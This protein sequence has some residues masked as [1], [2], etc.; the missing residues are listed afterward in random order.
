MSTP[1]TLASSIAATLDGMRSPIYSLPLFDLDQMRAVSGLLRA[2]IDD[3]SPCDNEGHDW[4]P[5]PS[6]QGIVAAWCHLDA[7]IKEFCKDDHE[8][9]LDML[10]DRQ[11]F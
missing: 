4:K 5:D 10:N 3:Q 8:Q 7:A 1:T 6:Y 11:S 9:E 2:F